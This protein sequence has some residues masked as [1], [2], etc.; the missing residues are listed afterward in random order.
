[1]VI[2]LSRYKEVVADRNRRTVAVRGGVLM[3][4]LQIA[5]SEKDQFTS[6]NEGYV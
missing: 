6:I 1:M 2:D 5:L 4:E 3:K